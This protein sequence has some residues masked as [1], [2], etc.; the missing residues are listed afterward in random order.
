MV[1]INEGLDIVATPQEPT[2][3]ENDEGIEI[4]ADP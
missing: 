2:I 3:V 4:I 1:Q